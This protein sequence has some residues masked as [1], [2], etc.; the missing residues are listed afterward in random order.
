VAPDQ[1]V[2]HDERDRLIA[3]EEIFEACEPQ[4]QVE[5]VGGPVTESLDPHGLLASGSDSLEHWFIVFV[6]C[7]LERLERAERQ[8]CEEIAR[9]CKD[10]FLGLA[11]IA[12]DPFAQ[13]GGR[14]PKSSV[15]FRVGGNLSLEQL[16]IL[17][18]LGGL[19]TS[20]VRLE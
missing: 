14:E 5:L 7:G 2:I 1:D 3:V 12:L 20:S 10:V 11:T 13:N 8:A 18:G 9:P 4:G 17:L 15:V 19:S 6:E 16:R